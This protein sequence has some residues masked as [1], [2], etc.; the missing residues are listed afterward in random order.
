MKQKKGKFSCDHCD[1][2]AKQKSVLMEHKASKH[3]RIRHPCDQCVYA[4]TSKT[5]KQQQI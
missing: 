4:A 3:D 2:V 1:Y 5:N